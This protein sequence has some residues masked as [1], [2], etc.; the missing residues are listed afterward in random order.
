[1]LLMLSSAVLPATQ[2][3][4]TSEQSQLYKAAVQTVPDEVMT[5]T[6]C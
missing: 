3:A 1:M 4:M 5:Q 6:I 2:V